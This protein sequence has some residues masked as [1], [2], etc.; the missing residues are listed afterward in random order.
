M[1]DFLTMALDGDTLAATLDRPD[2]PVKGA[3]LIVS[4][5]NELRSGAHRGMAALADRLAARGFATLRFDRRGVGDSSGDNGGFTA[6]GADIAAALVMLRTAVP[7]APRSIAFGNCDA[8]SALLLQGPFEGL[9]GLVLA[10]P[11][12]IADDAAPGA[13]P[14]PAAVR[15]RYFAKLKDP[16]EVL[17]L[18]GGKVDFRKLLRGIARARSATAPSPLAERLADRIAASTKPTHIL[19]ANRDT[20]ALAFWAA[21]KSPVFFRARAGACVTVLRRDTASHSFARPDDAKWL[22]ETLVAALTA[23]PTA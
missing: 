6:S 16:R 2:G 5:G 9:D 12:V 13:L 15:A 23:S 17:R 11:W 1:R 18:L 22:E 10:N 21:W 20:T 7:G 19:L 14:P 8:A 4:G 3:L